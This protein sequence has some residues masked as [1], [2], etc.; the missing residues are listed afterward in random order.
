MHSAVRQAREEGESGGGAVP[1]LAA[2]AVA[3]FLSLREKNALDDGRVRWSAKP[4]PHDDVL[5][6]TAICP[7]LRTN[8]LTTTGE[9][10]QGPDQDRRPHDRGVRGHL[11]AVRSHHRD[12]GDDDGACCIV[13]MPASTP[14]ARVGHRNSVRSHLLHVCFQCTALQPSADDERR[15]GRANCRQGSGA[16]REYHGVMCRSNKAA[17][18]GCSECQQAP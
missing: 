5:P 10:P 3:T 9:N 11:K 4:P 2:A 12:E 1:M 13:I 18:D 16:V 14:A 7:H 17:N 6:N 8:K 15:S